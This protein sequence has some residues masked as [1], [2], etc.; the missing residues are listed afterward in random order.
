M[1]PKEMVYT[2]TTQTAFLLRLRKACAFVHSGVENNCPP[3][4][5]RKWTDFFVAAVVA[6]SLGCSLRIFQ[7]QL[8]KDLRTKDLT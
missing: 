5:D 8:S 6:A 4:L 7:I 1:Q 2:V 3:G